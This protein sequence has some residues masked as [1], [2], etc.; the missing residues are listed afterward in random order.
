MQIDF[1]KIHQP[2]EQFGKL[3]KY[4]Y[5]YNSHPQICHNLLLFYK[6]IFSASNIK[7]KSLNPE[8]SWSVHCVG[9][10]V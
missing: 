7:N 1:L 5:I 2:H 8:N 9:P 4:I 10:A 6:I 3:N